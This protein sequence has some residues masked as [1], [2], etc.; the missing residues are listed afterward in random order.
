MQEGPQNIPLGVVCP[1]GILLSRSRIILDIHLQGPDA[2]K[3]RSE[4]SV[5]PCGRK[6]K[7]NHYF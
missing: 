3:T 4:S 6:L 5:S 2:D 1:I 7:K